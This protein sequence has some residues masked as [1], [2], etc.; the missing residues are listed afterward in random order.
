MTSLTRFLAQKRNLHLTGLAAA[1][2]LSIVNLPVASHAAVTAGGIAILGYTDYDTGGD[3]YFSIAALEDITAGTTLYFT[4]NG[5]SAGG[6]SFY[7]AS[8]TNGNGNETLIKLSFSSNVAA[9]TIMRSGFDNTGYT[10][11]ISSVIA[12]ATNG[13]T[14]SLLN[15]AQ[16]GIGDQIYAFEASANPPLVN[17]SSFIYLLDFGDNGSPGFEDAFS[18]ATGNL[19]TGL[20][21]AAN[22]AVTLPDP[23]FGDDA[24]DFHNGSFALNMADPDVIALNT[25]G[26]TK[27]QWLAVI[28]DYTNWLKINVQDDP[29]ADAESQLTALL[30]GVPEPGRAVL[31]AFGAVGVIMRRRRVA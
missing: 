16:S 23:S 31:L 7:G 13:D 30:V 18:S 14:Y 19:G 3:D 6:N 1:A 20:S 10:W 2:V 5:W 8:N 29:G 12:G 26:G 24:N 4:D 15:L 11:D 21:E 22:T 17:P 25:G 27:A 9:G 28:A